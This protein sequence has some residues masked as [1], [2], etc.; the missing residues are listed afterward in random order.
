MSPT[1]KA[2]DNCADLPGPVTDDVI[3]GGNTH[4]PGVLIAVNSDRST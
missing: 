3:A 4:A 2:S 1:S